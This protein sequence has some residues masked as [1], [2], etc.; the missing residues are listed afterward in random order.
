[1]ALYGVSVLLMEN[2]EHYTLDVF[3]CVVVQIRR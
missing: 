1:M 2:R 3:Y